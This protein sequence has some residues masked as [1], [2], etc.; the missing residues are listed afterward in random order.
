MKYFL[1][2]HK[3]S[4]G[5]VILLLTEVITA[6][7]TEKRFRWGFKKNGWVSFRQVEA[8]EGFGGKSKPTRVEIRNQNMCSRKLKNSIWPYPS[9]HMRVIRIVSPIF[10]L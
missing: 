4:V 7:H 9:I 1:K 5:E 3:D 2:R 10:P 8:E 6:G